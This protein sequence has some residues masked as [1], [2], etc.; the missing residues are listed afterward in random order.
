MKEVTNLIQESNHD[1]IHAGGKG[2][3][4][5]GGAIT[6]AT[7][8]TWVGIA[9]G[10]LTCIFMALQIEAAWRKRQSAKDKHEG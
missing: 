1:L 9:A 5:F 2:V 7:I 10:L 4:G 8:N 6:A 3:I